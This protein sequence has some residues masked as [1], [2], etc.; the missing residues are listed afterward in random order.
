[1]SDFGIGDLVEVKKDGGLSPTL[2]FFYNKRG[3]IS[4]LDI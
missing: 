4:R 1:M 2:R 3:M